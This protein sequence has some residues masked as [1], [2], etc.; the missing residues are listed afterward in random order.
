L[1]PPNGSIDGAFQLT[2]PLAPRTPCPTPRASR[3]AAH[4]PAQRP[5]VAGREVRAAAVAAHAPMLARAVVRVARAHRPPTVK[6][7]YR[8]GGR[9]SSSSYAELL[10]NLAGRNSQEPPMD[11]AAFHVGVPAAGPCMK[12]GP[13]NESRRDHVSVL[14]PRHNALRRRDLSLHHDRDSGLVVGRY[15]PSVRI[16]IDHDSPCSLLPQGHGSAVCHLRHTPTTPSLARAVVRVAQHHHCTS[17]ANANGRSRLT[18]YASTGASGSSSL[19]AV[20]T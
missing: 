14:D 15:R 17:V 13:A 18:W 3:A 10:H 12:N 9:S 16:L 8:G 20:T 1:T 7:R 5:P 6:H 19:S 4:P 11:I 2:G